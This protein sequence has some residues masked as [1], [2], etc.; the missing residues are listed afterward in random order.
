[1]ARITAS[2]YTSHVPAIGAAMDLGKTT[3]PYWQPLFKGYEPSRQWLK[4]NKPDVIFLPGNYTEVAAIALQAKKLGL[5]IPVLG[6]DG[7]DSPELEKIAGDALEGWTYSNHFSAE[8]PRPQLQAFI[9]TY[10]AEYGTAPDSLAC[11]GYDAAG[12]LADALSRAKSLE[13]KD[14]AA[15]IAE[16]KDFH[17][18]TGDIT[19]NAQRNADKP[20]VMLQYKGGKWKFVGSVPPITK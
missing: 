7:W 11:L 10:S 6:G 19:I 13:G 9:K 16:T 18:V 17:G 2:V 5:S 3:E 1:M 4:D 20:A 14:V 15:A 12:V 8:D